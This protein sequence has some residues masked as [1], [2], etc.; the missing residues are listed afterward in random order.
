MRTT[1]LHTVT[2]L[3][4]LVAIVPIGTDSATSAEPHTPLVETS[5]LPP[6]LADLAEGAVRLFDEAGLDLPDLRFVHHG[7]DRE[8]CRGWKGVHRYED[9][10]SEIGLCTDES[11][12]V[13]E[14][15]VIHETA[16]A[17]AAH[18][19]TD[20]RREAFRNLRGWEHWRA[21][22]WHESG[23]EHAAEILAWGLIDRPAGIVTIPDHECDDLEAGY[24]ALTGQEPL[25]GYRDYC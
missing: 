3:T 18:S 5:T 9:G 23:S 16:H 24:R 22:K 13:I 1:L 19:L 11:G 12:P 4:A 10:V 17:W 2:A 25:Y 20:E 21:D 7:D 8:P 14:W 6:A 15:L